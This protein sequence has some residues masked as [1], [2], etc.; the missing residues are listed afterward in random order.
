MAS[1]TGY[2]L[3]PKT[4]MPKRDFS[5][6]YAMFTNRYPEHKEITSRNVQKN[7]E[8]K[9]LFFDIKSEYNAQTVGFDEAFAIWEKNNPVMAEAHHSGRENKKKGRAIRKPVTET[10]NHKTPDEP[11]QETLDEFHKLVSEEKSEMM[12]DLRVTVNSFTNNQIQ[13]EKH[14]HD[15][16]DKL[17]ILQESM[18]E[19]REGV[20][21]FDE[22]L[23]TSKKL[24][25]T[26]FTTLEEIAGTMRELKRQR[27]GL[28]TL[29]PLGIGS[30]ED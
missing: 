9:K 12:D 21:I 17:D 24:K 29:S 10:P 27:H 26:V 22:K 20:S 4:G 2:F 1:A 28:G 23:R 15:L 19:F 8:T 6:P 7:P 13:L 3:V 16:L 14:Q 11:V 25:R 5:S 18:D 30:D